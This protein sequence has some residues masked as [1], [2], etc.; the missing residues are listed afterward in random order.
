M[1]IG[2]GE[3][4]NRARQ[5]RRSPPHQ[6]LRLAGIQPG[7]AEAGNDIVLDDSLDSAECSTLE[8]GGFSRFYSLDIVQEIIENKI[9]I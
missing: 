1:G 6:G 9:F 8:S 2:S 5:A 7:E 4:A 3:W